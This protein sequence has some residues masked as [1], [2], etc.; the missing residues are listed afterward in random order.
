MRTQARK[1]RLKN[2]SMCVRNEIWKTRK[3]TKKEIMKELSYRNKDR[4]QRES[5]KRRGPYSSAWSPELDRGL[6]PVGKAAAGWL[7]SL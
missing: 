1:E 4:M 5:R 3:Q 7:L 6:P 2:V